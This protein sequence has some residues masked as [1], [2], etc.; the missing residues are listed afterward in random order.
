MK[1]RTENERMA[2]LETTVKNLDDKVTDIQTDIKS[3]LQTLNKQPSLEAKI[4]SLE[5]KIDK[6]EK[7]GNLWKFLS[8]TFAA[9][10]GS[11]LTF[12]IINYLAN[13]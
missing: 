7:Q 6:Y 4:I 10:A 1:A 9:I 11:I 5:Q 3:I 8:P 12:L 13:I 2:I